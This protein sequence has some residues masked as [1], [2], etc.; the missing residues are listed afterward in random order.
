MPIFLKA[1]HQLESRMLEIGQSAS[2]GGAKMPLSL[3][4]FTAKEPKLVG[5]SADHDPGLTRS[6]FLSFE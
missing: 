1:N 3:P 6:G 4:L 5:A 2:E